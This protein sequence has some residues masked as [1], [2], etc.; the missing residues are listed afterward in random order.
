MD[1][2]AIG[3]RLLDTKECAEYLNISR[4]SLYRLVEARRL[5]FLKLG[6]KLLFP[7]RKIESFLESQS[8]VPKEIESRR[9]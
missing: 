2:E 3:R 7:L 4:C 8:F 1:T 6:G 5:P 9:D